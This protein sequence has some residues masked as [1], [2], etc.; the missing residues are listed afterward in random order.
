MPSPPPGDPVKALLHRHRALCERAVDPLEIAAALEAH[1]MTDRTAARY[2]HRDVFSLA[3]EMYARVPRDSAVCDTPATAPGTAPGGDPRAAGTGH[4]TSRAG[5]RPVLHARWAVC[6]LLPG[7]V[8][9]LAVVGLALPERGVRLAEALAGALALAAPLTT[10]LRHAPPRAARSGAA[11]RAWV[12]W[13]LAYAVLG[14]GLLR[15]TV[16]DGTGR[17]WA[18]SAV[19]VLG[20][21]AAVAPGMACARLFT[22]R[23]RRR[24]GASR[25]LAEFAASVRPLLITV[26]ALYAGAVALAFAGADS[27]L[28][29][30]GGDLA[31]GPETGP[32]AAP[33]ASLATGP[34]TGLVADPAGPAGSGAV[35]AGA[36]ALAVLLWL[37]RMLA[38]HGSTR[39]P[40]LV[41]AAV[42]TAQAAPLALVGAA[43]LPGCGFLASPAETAALTWSAPALACGAGAVVLLV[44]AVRV[45]GRASAHA[46]GGGA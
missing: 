25:G 18:P 30:V 16:P 19:V 11:T 34:V 46:A 4:D 21:A 14:D 36:G 38:A 12:C 22:A 23:A 44:R 9:A 40:A 8:C 28:G 39:A 43:R 29:A 20:L 1:G 31:A 17:P 15:A 35:C 41:Y 7:A 42:G 24:L 26:V 10:A 45:L 3:E 32:D 13:L 33:G 5:A 27:V 37:G 2:R 6:A